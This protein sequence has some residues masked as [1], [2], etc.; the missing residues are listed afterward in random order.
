M[1]VLNTLHNARNVGSPVVI[2]YIGRALPLHIIILYLISSISLNSFI[3]NDHHELKHKALFKF[4][5]FVS[6][7]CTESQL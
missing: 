1:V 3:D 2:V 6:S 4:V 5:S 7:L